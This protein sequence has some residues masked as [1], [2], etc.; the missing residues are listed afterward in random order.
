M[1]ENNIWLVI[2]VIMIVIIMVLILF[3]L[4][5]PLAYLPLFPRPA[6]RTVNVYVITTVL[7]PKPYLVV[8]QASLEASM[9]KTHMNI[10]IKYIAINTYNTSIVLKEII[11]PELNKTITINKTIK[12]HR[13]YIGE[14]YIAI[15]I[16]YNDEWD[17]GTMHNIMFKYQVNSTI[18]TMNITVAVN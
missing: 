12:P 17:K 3:G 16:P 5:F 4:M 1:E 13:E 6:S 18:K 7:N 2:V 8:R 10:T 11:V 9:N 15:N 14:Q